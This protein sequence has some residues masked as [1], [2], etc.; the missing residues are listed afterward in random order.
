MTNLVLKAFLAKL[1]KLYLTQNLTFADILYLIIFLCFR[2]SMETASMGGL[3]GY[4]YI[5]PNHIVK[6]SLQ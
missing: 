2:I 6:T 4:Q 3:A 1:L 5:A